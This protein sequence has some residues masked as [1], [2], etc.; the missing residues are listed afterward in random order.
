MNLPVGA[1]VDVKVAGGSDGSGVIETGGSDGRG[2]TFTVGAGNVMEGDR[3]DVVMT[4]A[5]DG[6]KVVAIGIELEGIEK[7]GTGVLEIGANVVDMRVGAF[8]GAV[9]GSGK[10]SREG[11]DVLEMMDIGEFVAGSN[12]EVTESVGAREAGGMDW[13]VPEQS[14]SQALL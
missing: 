8:V 2:V 3:E 6:R 5:R 1:S 12:G 7:V 10:M 9:E 4:A 13:L 14:R 11:A